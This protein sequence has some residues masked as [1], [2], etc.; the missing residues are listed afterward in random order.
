MQDNIENND[1]STNYF[2]FIEF[3]SLHPF[4]FHLYSI[5]LASFVFLRVQKYFYFLRILNN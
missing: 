4:P 3:I 1:C 5:K 2:D